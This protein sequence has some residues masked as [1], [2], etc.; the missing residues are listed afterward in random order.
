MNPLDQIAASEK[1]R[2]CI[3]ALK[4]V[5]ITSCT[6]SLIKIETDGGITGYGEA[7]G[8]GPMIRGNLKYLERVLLGQDPLEIDKLFYAMTGLQHPNRPHVPTVSGVDIALWDIAG[9][10]LGRPVSQLLRGQYR[11]EIPIY[12][13]SRGP[14]D[15]FDQGACREW[16]RQIEEHPFKYQGIKM[17]W[18][19][20]FGKQLARERTRIGGR[21]VMYRPSEIQIVGRGYENCR[22]A[23]D[24]AIDMMVHCN[25]QFDLATAVGLVQALA[26]IH[27]LWIEDALPVPY[28]EAWKTLKAASPIPILTGEKLELP[29]EFMPFLVHG[30]VDMMQPDIVFAGGFSGLWKIA[31]L[32]DQFYVPITT[33]NVGTPVQIAA[34]AHFGASTRNFVMSETRLGMRNVL[35]DLI[36]ETLT[37]EEGKLH[38]PTGPGL[39][40]TVL[41]EAVRANMADG[42]PYWDD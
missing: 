1:G 31:E 42:E 40:I 26:P 23:L 17:S 22:A 33:H 34:T 8:P 32:A 6:Q 19:G 21:E 20:M 18:R 4:A 38:L 30:A 36:A 25:N 10:V 9:K 2:L 27:P 7:G 5:Q 12:A 39:G 28:S 35:E 13:N 37:V 15:W 11:T 41:E 29:R 3:T 16:A 14:E 24:P